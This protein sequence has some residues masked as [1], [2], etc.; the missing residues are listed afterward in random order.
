MKIPSG[1]GTTQDEKLDIENEKE[2]D[3]N[4]KKNRKVYF[5]VDY[6]RYFLR[7]STG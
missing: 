4:K 3:I 1:A 6:S 7:I 5:C 2:P